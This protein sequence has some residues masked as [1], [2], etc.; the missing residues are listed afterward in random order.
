MRS[1]AA[2]ARSSAEFARVRSS[3]ARVIR[4]CSCSVRKHVCFVRSSSST[5]PAE[6]KLPVSVSGGQAQ[7]PYTY[8]KFYV[9]KRPNNL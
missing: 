3:S 5:S 1:S 6:F 4:D 8:P 9:L 7:T 2:A